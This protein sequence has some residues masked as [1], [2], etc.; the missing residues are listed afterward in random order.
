MPR[1]SDETEGMVPEDLGKEFL[2]YL[3]V[4][5]QITTIDDVE[6][7]MEAFDYSKSNFLRCP[8][9]PASLY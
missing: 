8:C 7:Q 2:A 1:Y 9:C 6:S 3:A 4:V 5:V